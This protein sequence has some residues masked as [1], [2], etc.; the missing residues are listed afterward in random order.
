MLA[1]W[2]YSPSCTLCLLPTVVLYSNPNHSVLGDCCHCA[3]LSPAYTI[4]MCSLSTIRQLYV[5][6][7][8]LCNWCVA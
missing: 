1:E 8:L 6:Q 4:Y 3:L 5:W 2:E 7:N